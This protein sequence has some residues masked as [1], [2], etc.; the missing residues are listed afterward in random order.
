VSWCWFGWSHTAEGAV[1]SAAVTDDAGEAAGTLAAWPMERDAGPEGTAK[2]DPRIIAPAG[3][4]AVVSLVLAPQGS[5]LPFDDPAVAHAIRTVLSLPPPDAVSTLLLGDG[6][7]VGAVTVHRPAAGARRFDDP[8]ARLFPARRLHVEAGLFGR[9]PAP[10]GP[11]GQ[12]H[13]SA[14]PWPWDRF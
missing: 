9:A 8:F 6:S 14:N 4:P 1:A 2:I 3:E 13:G 10:T 12:R 11:D 7:F 5:A